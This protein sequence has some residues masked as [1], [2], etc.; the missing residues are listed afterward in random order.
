MG[1]SQ[2]SLR[3]G[4]AL[5]TLFSPIRCP[6]PSHLALGSFSIAQSQYTRSKSSKSAYR[7]YSTRT[8][9]QEIDRL[10]EALYVDT[11]EIFGHLSRAGLEV[12]ASGLMKGEDLGMYFSYGAGLFLT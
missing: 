11:D 10:R 12:S 3:H 6:Y 8:R 4:I 7:G 9:K 5:V 2:S 1:A